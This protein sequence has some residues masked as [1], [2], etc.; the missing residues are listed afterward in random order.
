MLKGKVIKRF[1]HEKNI[2]GS[3]MLLIIVDELK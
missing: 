1:K 2:K 3:T